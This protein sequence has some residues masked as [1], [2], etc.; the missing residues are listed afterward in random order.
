MATGGRATVRKQADVD[1]MMSRAVG[2][3]TGESTVAQAWARLFRHLNQARGK[4]T[5]PTSP[6]RRSSSSRTGSA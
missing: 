3:L 5:W 1:A 2:E 6:A 4:G